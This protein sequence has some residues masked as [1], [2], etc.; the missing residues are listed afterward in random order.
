M[1]LVTFDIDMEFME[2]WRTTPMEHDEDKMLIAWWG[3]EA[4]KKNMEATE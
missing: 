4:C 1:G 3:W 2:W